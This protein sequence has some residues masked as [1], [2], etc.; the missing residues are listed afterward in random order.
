[1]RLLNSSSAST[2]ASI[3]SSGTS[4]LHRFTCRTC[5]SVCISIHILPH[6]CVCAR[7]M[8]VCVLVCVCIHT[9]THT[10]THTQVIVCAKRPTP[11]PLRAR[12]CA[13][14]CESSIIDSYISPLTRVP[15]LSLSSTPP[16]PSP[17]PSS[18]YQWPGRGDLRWTPALQTRCIVSSL[19]IATYQANKYTPL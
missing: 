7:G 17:P 9:H 18:P 4:F 13:C 10:H 15:H 8:C 3:L 11:L 1:M 14:P 2:Y 5:V 12:A 6:L 19:A 16:P